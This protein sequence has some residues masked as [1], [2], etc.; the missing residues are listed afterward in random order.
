MV[1]TAILKVAAS[2]S[3]IITGDIIFIFPIRSTFGVVNFGPT[4]PFIVS[5]FVPVLDSSNRNI[6]YGNTY[7]ASTYE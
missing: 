2:D 1:I 5:L 6:L 7:D 3:F 4:K